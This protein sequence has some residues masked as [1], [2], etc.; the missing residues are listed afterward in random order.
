M[1]AEIAKLQLRRVDKRERYRCRS[2]MH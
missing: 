1:I 2:A